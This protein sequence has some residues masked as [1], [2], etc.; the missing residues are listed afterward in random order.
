MNVTIDDV[1]EAT[2]DELQARFDSEEFYCQKCNGRAGLLAG[3]ILSN[4][5]LGEVSEKHL[6]WNAIGFC[7]NHLREKA[8]IMFAEACT[9]IKRAR[10]S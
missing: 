7:C 2:R 10:S 5:R 6:S 4:T 1:E 3:F 8:D 9:K